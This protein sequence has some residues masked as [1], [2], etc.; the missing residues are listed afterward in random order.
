MTVATDSGPA[1]VRALRDSDSH[2][3]THGIGCTT[4]LASV[5]PNRL[6][7]VLTFNALSVMNVD[8]RM[9]TPS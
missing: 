2:Q 7:M 9:R 3:L 1:G 4:V 6:P 5:C 8:G